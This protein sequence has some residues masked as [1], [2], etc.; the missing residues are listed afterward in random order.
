MELV[1]MLFLLKLLTHLCWFEYN[2]KWIVSKHKH[3]GKINNFLKFVPVFYSLLYPFF[4]I[5][6]AYY[7]PPFQQ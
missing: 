4:S 7:W 6:S 1:H 2:L 5:F 3:T